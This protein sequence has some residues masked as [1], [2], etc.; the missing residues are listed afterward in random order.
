MKRERTPEQIAADRAKAKRW[1][2]RISHERS[3]INKKRC[4]REMIRALLSLTGPRT[5]GTDP[6]D[7]DEFKL[8]GV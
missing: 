1:A 8:E 3:P 6:L 5:D 7:R 2:K 4:Q